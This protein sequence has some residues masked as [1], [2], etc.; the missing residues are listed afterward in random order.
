MS[1]AVI[2]E[3]RS[4]SHERGFYVPVATEDVYRRIWEP[5]AVKLKT[6]LILRFGIGVEIGEEEF[7][8]LASELSL[9]YA[10]IQEDTQIEERTHIGQRIERLIA[11]LGRVFEENPKARVY[12]G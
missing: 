4:N 2:F 6:D 8:K 10:D 7:P 9:L 3:N 1:V 11:E 5:K 12:I